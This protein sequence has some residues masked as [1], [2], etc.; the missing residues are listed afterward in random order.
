[1]YLLFSAV[2]SSSISRSVSRSVGRS[3]HKN[4]PHFGSHSFHP[5]RLKFGMEIKCVRMKVVFV[6][7][8]IDWK[9]CDGGNGL[10]QKVHIFQTDSQTWS[11]FTAKVGHDPKD[12]WLTVWADWQKGAW[13]W[14]W[15]VTNRCMTSKQIHLPWPDSLEMRTHTFIGHGLPCPYTL[16][17][18][19]P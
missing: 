2:N 6:L 13:Q 7:M 18:P 1:M 12:S 10:L 9:G 4:S 14:E 15:P 19:P 17:T 8:P 11:R 16:A 5:R 3:V